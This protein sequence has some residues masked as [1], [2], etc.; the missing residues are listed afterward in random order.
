[1]ILWKENIE[2]QNLASTGVFKVWESTFL[3]GVEDDSVELR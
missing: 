3:M 1:M 2:L